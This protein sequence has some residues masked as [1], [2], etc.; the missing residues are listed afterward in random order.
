MIM[1][2]T[3]TFKSARTELRKIFTR[4]VPQAREKG[5]RV[6]L[7]ECIDNDGDHSQS[8]SVSFKDEKGNWHSSAFMFFWEKYPDSLAGKM[9]DL[10]TALKKEGFKI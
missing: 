6:Y 4:L 7:E 8:F 1:T 5:Y 2:K 10:K 9:L 3:M